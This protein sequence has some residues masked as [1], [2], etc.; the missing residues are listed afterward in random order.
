MHSRLEEHCKACRV[1]SEIKDRTKFLILLGCSSEFTMTFQIL[2]TLWQN[3]HIG[4]FS[5][6]R[7][8]ENVPA[9]Q[10]MIGLGGEQFKDILLWHVFEDMSKET[11]WWMHLLEKVTGQQPVPQEHAGCLKDMTADWLKWG[12]ENGYYVPENSW[13][14]R[15]SETF[16]DEDEAKEQ[17]FRRSQQI[18]YGSTE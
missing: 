6:F 8:D 17:A 14:N 11:H 3:S 15:I 16:C 18:K 2:K 10:A 1:A 9:Y 12:E 7:Q 13:A 5:A 4:K